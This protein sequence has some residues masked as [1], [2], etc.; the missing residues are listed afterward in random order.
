M[1]FFNP[2]IINLMWK[3]NKFFQK[4]DKYHFQKLS[5]SSFF[6]GHFSLQ[7][8]RKTIF[9]INTIFRKKS[10]YRNLLV[11]PIHMTWPR[12]N[13]VAESSLF[14]GHVAKTDICFA[15]DTNVKSR[16]NFSRDL[17]SNRQVHADF[18]K[19]PNLLY[20]SYITFNLVRAHSVF[21][22]FII[23]SK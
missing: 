16:C 17:V 22:E 7:S 8:Y 3:L 12:K 13:S 6:L 19:M 15:R 23:S 9:F 2:K 11:L 20:I 5:K 14:L 21:C 18:R 1:L 4:I 10:K